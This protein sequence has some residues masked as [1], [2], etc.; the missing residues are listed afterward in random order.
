MNFA[1]DGGVLSNVNPG[2]RIRNLMGDDGPDMMGS[3]YGPDMMQGGSLSTP[4]NPGPSMMGRTPMLGTLRR[5]RG[6]PV[7]RDQLPDLMD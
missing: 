1:E 5:Q 4:D 7:V 6:L 2:S 3:D